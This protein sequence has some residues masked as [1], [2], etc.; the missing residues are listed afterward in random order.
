MYLNFLFMKK[1]L[2]L[3]CCLFVVFSLRAGEVTRRYSF[4]E[5]SLA[6]LDQY[7]T[8]RFGNTL[9]SGLTGE[10]S[11]PYHSVAL[12]LPPG[13]TAVSIEIKGEGLTAVPGHYTLYPRQYASPI[14]Q[15]HDGVFVK[16]EE[17][18]RSAQLYP[19]VMEGNLSTHFLNGFGFAL[20]TFT[21]V[22]YRPATGE[23]AYYRE[24][25]VTIRS[26]PDVKAARALKNLQTTEKVRSK[27]A[28]LAQNPQ[29]M[30]SYPVRKS[31][32]VGYQILI[33]TSFLFEEGFQPLT[34]YYNSRGLTSHITSV[35]SIN[36]SG[37]GADLQEKIRN[38]IISE[39]QDSGIEHVILG[40]DI[41]HV[42]YRGF[43]CYVVSG[44]G[45]EDSNIPADLYFAAL[46][47]TWNDDND[48]KWGEPGEDDLLPDISVGRMPFSTVAELENMVN[49]SVNYQTNPGEWEMNKPYLVSEFL[50]DDPMTWGADYLELLIDDH[51]DNGYFTYGM[52]SADNNIT[53]LYDTPGYNWSSG[54]VIA[55]INAGKSFIHHSGHSNSNYMMRLYTWD[56][57]NSNFSKVNGVDQNFQLMYTHGCICGAFDEED[58]IAEKSVSIDNFL[59][60][61]IFNSR[62]GWFNQ[63]QTEGPSAHLHREFISAVYHPDADSAIRELGAAHSMS[64]IMTAPWSNLPGEFEPGAQRWCMYD[65]NVLGD[66]VLKV[67]TKD[68]PVGMASV[69][70]GPSVH[71]SPNPC[72]GQLRVVP[73]HLFSGKIQI[74]VINSL[75]KETYS[76][77]FENGPGTGIFTA[78]LSHLPSGHYV[79]RL[80]DGKQSGV[81]KFIMAQ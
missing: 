47:G 57:N 36:A 12:L 37:T 30:E 9:Q 75:G 7:H 40:G 3:L 76:A 61:G 21:P 53:R 5:P 71:L 43:Y 72:S 41:A 16:K 55:G 73:G 11:L 64:K 10:P 22:V 6:A 20:S 69:P 18:Y 56:I 17:V 24:V 39:Y 70:A 25:T 60:G 48:W 77:V 15:G 4:T 34:E 38:H 1:I 54:Q 50:Y 81:G 65:C 46:D 78:D 44:S 68:D 67:W 32:T 14:S 2:L 45:Y 33:I 26:R 19:G 59:A 27:V 62:Y 51:G 79:C 28:R 49:K 13:E 31:A 35:E 29:M 58:C 63:G 74:T 80:T 42:P 23:V 8:I 66:P 52:P